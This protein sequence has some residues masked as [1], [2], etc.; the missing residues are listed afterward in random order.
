M[1]LSVVLAMAFLAFFTS[2]GEDDDTNNAPYFVGFSDGGSTDG[3]VVIDT[4]QSPPE[5]DSTYSF[6]VGDDGFGGD[7]NDNLVTNA[8]VIFLASVSNITGSVGVSLEITEEAV[9]QSGQTVTP[10]YVTK[11]TKFTKIMLAIYPSEIHH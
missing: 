2:C 1:K 8:P 10:G 6:I 11:F 3:G 4:S 7:Q 5:G 9:D